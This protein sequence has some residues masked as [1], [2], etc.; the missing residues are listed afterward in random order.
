[1]FN[2]STHDLKIE[3]ANCVV[4]AYSSLGHY[5][6]E[7]NHRRA[8]NLVRELVDKHAC[9]CSLPS[10]KY[11]TTGHECWYDWALRWGGKMNGKGAF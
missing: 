6:S 4:T 3:L 10:T 1:M 9:D 8:L 2:Q 7:E 5:K 11:G